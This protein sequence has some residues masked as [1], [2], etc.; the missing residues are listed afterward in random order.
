MTIFFFFTT[1]I[2][3]LP[4]RKGERF[5]VQNTGEFI[6]KT[7]FPK[8]LENARH[9]GA[10]YFLVSD[11]SKI[12]NAEITMPNFT[13]YGDYLEKN[14]EEWNPDDPMFGDQYHHVMIKSSKAWSKTRGSKE[15]IVAV[16]DNEFE[17]DH[18]D[19]TGQWWVNE[20]E[21]PN[22]GIDDDNNGYVDDINGWDFIERGPNPDHD[23]GPS[24][25]THV[26]G[27]IAAKGN[28]GVGVIGVAPKV[29]I[30][31]LRW[32][33]EG[34]RWNSALILET[35]LYAVNNGAKI[36]NTSYNIDNVVDDQ[37]YLEAIKYI[38]K[39]DVLLFNSAGNNSRKNPPRQIIEE[40]VLVC[41]VQTKKGRNSDR[42]SRFSNFGTGID[43]CAP[44][45]P[46]LAPVQGRYQGKSRYG[47]LRGTSMASP[48][49]AGIAA[50]IWSDNPNFSAQEV[51]EKLEE[52]ADDIQR[53]NRSRYK[54]LIGK[55]RVNAFKAVR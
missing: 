5:K 18:D 28:N 32:Y 49:A 43:V 3:A 37:A 11:I 12:T 34:R 25:G 27:I 13:Y 39:N 44:G 41:S 33:G 50:L 24:H 30:M 17:M 45:D 10:N 8:E 15:I 19:L 54:G 23:D 4:I 14:L 6:V 40:I 48:I 38:V 16:T 52:T 26:A 1:T 21:I 46:I 51:R 36:I 7:N 9:L 20:G 2:F 31:P 47:E 22:N 35:Y 29:K 55:G 53:N 42:V